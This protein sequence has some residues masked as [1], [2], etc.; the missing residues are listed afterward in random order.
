MFRTSTPAF[1]CALAI[2]AALSSSRGGEAAD[3]LKVDR[4]SVFEF[5]EQPTL[6]REGDS[7]TVRFASRDYCDAT[8]VVERGDG[9]ILRHLASGVLG[10]NAPAPF[11]P[12]SLKQS[13]TWDG[14]DEF[15]KYVDDLHGVRMRVSLGLKA[16]LERNLGWHPKRRLGL[17]KMPRAVACKE[18]VYAYEGAGCEAV[19]LFDHEGRYLRT[20]HPFPSDKVKDVKGLPWHTFPDGHRAPRARGY[21]RSTYM[22]GGEG[23]T[24]SK[25]ASSADAFDV[26]AGRIANVSNRLCRL[27]TDGTCGPHPIYGPATRMPYPPQ[28]IALSPDGKWLYLTGCYMAINRANMS[29]HLARVRWRHGVYRTEYGGEKP[30]RLWLGSPDKTGKGDKLFDHPS[31]VC[32]D[33]RGRV[34]IADNHNDRVQIYSPEGRLLKSHPVEGPAVLQ[35]HQKTGELYVFSWTMALA[36]GYS[37]PPHKVRPV[38]RVFEPFKSAEAKLSVSLP[39]E[40]YQGHSRGFMGSPHYDECP[41]RA[42][43]DGYTD[44]PTIWLGTGWYRKWRPEQNRGYTL[45]RYRLKGGKMVLLEKWNDRVA[46]ALKVWKPTR[47]MRRRLYVDPRK[48]TLYVAEDDPKALDVLT[49]IDPETGETGLLKLPYTAEEFAFDLHGHVY[50]RCAQVVGRFRLDTMREVPFDYGENRSFRWSSFARPGRLISA[51]VLP[52]NK[53][54]WWHES[55]MAVNPGG[56]LVVSCCNSKPTR[57]SSMA[58]ADVHMAGASYKPQIYPGRLRYSEIHVYDRH[59]RALRQDVVRGVM[60][61]HG[62]WIDPRGNVYYL[63]GGHRVYSGGKDF[64]PMTGCVMKFRP[65]SGK[66]YALR[67]SKL[68]PVAFSPESANAPALPQVSCGTLGRFAIE[69]ASWVYP[70]IG[71]VHPVA[72]CQCWNCRFTVDYFGRVF[73]PESVRNQVAVL[74]TNG[75]LIMHVGRYGNADDGVPLVADPAY[76]AVKPRPLGGDEVGLCYANYVATHTDHR[77]FIYDAANDRILSVKLGYHREA[78]VPLPARKNAPGE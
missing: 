19:R 9:K 67:R 60:D 75:N 28:S 57:K 38:L 64:L 22:L 69:G 77:L 55:G 1:T 24:R 74:D 6:T 17:R 33:D 43:L 59:G 66:F 13:V 20:V 4:K 65:G 49:R 26:R 10:A 40:G 54:V 58:G 70:G 36:Y 8:V 3:D 41:Y 39:L 45:S 25:W 7:V 27:N 78:R 56:Q 50:L 72:P 48:G 15:G 71:Y 37:A 63:A 2:L 18:G 23:D 35:I 14:K 30:P 12:G 21:W 46:S 53:P 5:A 62:T 44:P 52:G 42:T 32:V 73:A 61:G 11:K 31:S 29:T 76:R 16:R 47:L 68:V 34:Y 51:L